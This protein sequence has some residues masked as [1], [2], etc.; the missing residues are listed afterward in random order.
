MCL[1]V[2]SFRHRWK[3][4]SMHGYDVSKKNLKIDDGNLEYAT[5]LQFLYYHDAWCREYIDYLVY[6]WPPI[7]PCNPCE[8]TDS[9]N[10]QGDVIR[11]CIAALRGHEDFNMSF[12]VSGTCPVPSLPTLY[13][14]VCQLCQLVQYIDAAVD[15]GY[16]KATQLHVTRLQADLE[17]RDDPFIARW[18]S[19][20]CNQRGCYLHALL[21]EWS[22]VQ[23]PLVT[24]SLRELCCAQC[25]I[26]TR[27]ARCPTEC[28][29]NL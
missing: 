9:L 23:F 11:I 2:D 5:L 21:K 13:R 16:I 10:M 24:V 25:A 7:H 14:Q 15:T 12:W 18:N 27:A 22:Y 6:F 3:L 19:N 1:G 8:Y 20:H 4:V 17:Y 26:V 29:P 28:R